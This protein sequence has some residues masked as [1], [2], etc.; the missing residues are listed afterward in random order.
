LI[1]DPLGDADWVAFEKEDYKFLEYDIN[2][3]NYITVPVEGAGVT[4]ILKEAAAK[5]LTSG[6]GLVIQVNNGFIV[7]NVEMWS[8]PVTSRTVIIDSEYPEAEVSGI[9]SAAVLA[10]L[11]EGPIA[12]TLDYK[13][14]GNNEYPWFKT[15][16]ADWTELTPKGNVSVTNGEGTITFVLNSIAS[17]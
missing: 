6:E 2:E 17:P 12:V 4:V 1:N 8:A 15:I 9:V 5:K 10:M 16:T 13:A 7:E 11:P 14:T 3:W